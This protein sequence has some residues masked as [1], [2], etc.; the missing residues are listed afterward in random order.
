MVIYDA[1]VTI[2]D[3]AAPVLAPPTGTLRGSGGPGGWHKGPETLT[4][5]ASDV[6]GIK[7]TVVT[8]DAN[9]HDAVDQVC[10]YTRLRPC[11]ASVT[12]THSVDLSA[13]ADGPH[14]LRASAAD[15]AGQVTHSDP[16]EVKIDS[17]APLGPKGLR[18]ARNGDGSRRLSWANPSQGTA[19]PIVAARYAVCR[20][21]PSTDCQAEGRSAGVDIG[22]LD[23]RL[24]SGGGAWDGLV[25]LEDE[26]AN[27]DRGSGARVSLN[28][29]GNSPTSR[30]LAR[31]RI[32]RVSR[33]GGRLRVTGT[34]GRAATGR[35]AL[36]VRA[37]RGGPLLARGET[38]VRRGRWHISTRLPR[39][40]R[41]R[42]AALVTVR[43]RGDRRHAPQSITRPIGRT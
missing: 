9:R 41:G 36:R 24:P 12:A 23:V 32:K 42:R 16:V 14:Q 1:T 40:L 6:S 26:A 28:L 15:A 10:D 25:W 29:P 37:R 22:A 33:S 35:V 11:P 7:R 31:L 13:L 38:R 17:R 20:P 8:I 5:N 21:E 34:I 43:Y 18:V 4:I 39:A 3:P 2:D 30:R 27:H 19:A